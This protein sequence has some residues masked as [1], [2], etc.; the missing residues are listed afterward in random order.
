MTRAGG[1]VG[2]RHFVGAADFRVQVVHL[3]RESVWRKPFGFRV[4]IEECPVDLFGRSTDDTM[5]ADGV[6]GHDDYSLRLAMPA[7]LLNE[8]G[9]PGAQQP[10][11]TNADVIGQD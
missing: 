4:R 6:R 7:T 2:E 10:E 11:T 3:A 9:S 1:E 8:A 5:K